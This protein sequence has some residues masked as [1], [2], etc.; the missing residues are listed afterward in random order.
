VIDDSGVGVCF[1]FASA[2]VAR[3]FE[4]AYDL[5][6]PSAKEV[7]PPESLR[8]AYDEM[9]GYFDTPPQHALTVATM[10][11]WPDRQS[12]DLKWVHVAIVGVDE[13]EAV[14]VV[15]STY[16]GKQLIRS[17]EWGRP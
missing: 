5:L 9:V 12:G 3:R 1:E 4:R 13:T 16:K 17:V 7:W 10:D 2:L 6:T 14:T 8:D 15:A 11:E